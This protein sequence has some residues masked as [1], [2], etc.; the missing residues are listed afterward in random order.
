M[1]LRIILILLVLLFVYSCTPVRTGNYVPPKEPKMEDQEQ[2]EQE[3]P[4][5][6]DARDRFSDT[7]LVVLEPVRLKAYASTEEVLTG[8][9][10]DK[11]LRN[12]DNGNYDKACEKFEALAETY[13]QKDSLWFESNFYLAECMIT[14]NQLLEAEQLL[15]KLLVNPAAPQSV[16]EM[17]LVRIGQIKCVL[18]FEKEAKTYFNKLESKFPNSIYLELANCNS[19]N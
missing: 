17:L 9:E 15:Q 13:N 6:F 16:T 14:N 12:F 4:R 19:V 2:K 18:G 7:T 8:S 3:K 1:M 5:A 10:F 11:A